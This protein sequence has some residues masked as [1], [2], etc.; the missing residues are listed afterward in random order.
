MVENPQILQSNKREHC[1]IEKSPPRPI[2][3]QERDRIR[4]KSQA[5]PS[6][7][8]SLPSL[9]AA[10]AA[11]FAPEVKRTWSLLRTRSPPPSTSAAGLAARF[12]APNPRS[13]PTEF[14]SHDD[15][16]PSCTRQFSARMI[17]HRAAPHSLRSG[18]VRLP[19]YVLLARSLS[20]LRINEPDTIMRE[21]NA[22]PEVETDRS[23][24][25]NKDRAHET[26]AENDTNSGSIALT[27]RE[28]ESSR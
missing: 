28:R 19:G 24:P 18:N 27:E 10:G 26:R 2:E 15:L 5:T 6:W 23:G 11:V 22:T 8:E 9:R 4:L 20:P 12:I 3:N 17:N 21:R 14:I 1:R 25:E 13:P 16:L 7:P